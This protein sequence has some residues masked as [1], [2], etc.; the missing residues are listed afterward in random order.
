MRRAPGYYLVRPILS[1]AALGLGFCVA[2][3]VLSVEARRT[4]S[5][6]LAASIL[7][8][9]ALCLFLEREAF[10]RSFPFADGY[11]GERKVARILSPL[12]AE[13]YRL[14]GP[15]LLGHRRIGRGDIDQV[16][17][18]PA[19]VFAIEVKAWKGRLFWQGSSLRQGRWDRTHKISKCVRHAMFLKRRIPPELGVKWIEAVT[20]FTEA[21]PRGGCRRLKGYWVVPADDLVGFIRS[22]SKK[23][24]EEE[25]A[26][27][28]AVLSVR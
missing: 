17:V 10:V 5:S 26:W 4:G 28:A 19:G 24:T 6:W 9:V 16:V 1:R 15:R 2:V 25:C 13:G 7:A 11:A 18:G 27:I 21:S 23:L 12:E 14:L 3:T 22:R 8:F 20:V